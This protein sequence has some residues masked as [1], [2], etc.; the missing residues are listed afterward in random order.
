M[1]GD[2]GAV[3]GALGA[4][5]FDGPDDILRDR[6]ADSRGSVHRG[7]PRRVEQR[8]DHRAAE[9]ADKGLAVAVRD[10][11]DEAHLIGAH[12]GTTDED[13]VRVRVAVELHDSW[14]RKR[15]LHRVVR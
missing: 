10:A 5:A 13:A 9:S 12:A 11:I 14:L 15:R 6:L 8:K 3:D 2:D 4:A 1:A 7:V